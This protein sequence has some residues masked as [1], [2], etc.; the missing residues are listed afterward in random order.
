[1]IDFEKLKQAH[2]LCLA[3]K[4]YF[5]NIT[6]GLYDK[7][8][9]ISLYD[10]DANISLIRNFECV[11]ELL[12]KLQELTQSKQKYKVGQEVWKPNVK[13]TPWSYIITAVDHDL[14]YYLNDQSDW[15]DEQELHPSKQALIEAQI[16]Y[17]GQ[18]YCDEHN[19]VFNGLSLPTLKGGIK[20]LKEP[21]KCEHE[22]DGLSY[23]TNPPKNKCMKCGEF[24]T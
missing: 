6:L 1:M 14:G 11:G 17:W 22:R 18:L 24:Y 12:Y 19:G 15:H 3:Y 20:G 21:I 10:S 7:L 2:E 13:H 9:I 16:E 4:R 8:D 23:Y 5:F